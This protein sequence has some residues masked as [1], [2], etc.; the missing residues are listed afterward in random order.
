MSTSSRLIWGS[1]TSWARMCVTVLS[2]TLLVP[3]YLSHWSIK[4]YGVWLAIQS[5]L[6]LLTIPDT[7]HQTF[8]GYEFLRFGKDS[9]EKIGLNLY[10]GAAFGLIISIVQI[11]F[12]VILLNTDSLGSMLGESGLSDN[13]ILHEAGLVLLIQGF[14]WLLC[15]SVSGL[16]SRSLLTFGYFPR[17]SLWILIMGINTSF[18]PVIPVMFGAGLLKTAI[19]C[20]LSTVVLAVL[21][22]LD[23][24]HLLRKEK[25]PFIFPSLKLG[26]KNFTHSLALSGRIALENTRQQG[27]R[28]IVAPLAGITGLAA[29]S[30]MRT[31]SNF[32]LQGLNTI[33]YPLMPELSRFLHQ[34][35]QDRMEAGFGT[36]WI[37]LI[38]VLA[39]S[40]VILQAFAEPL[41][42]IWTRGK[43]PF[44]PS[45]FAVLSLSVL[46]Y[47]LGQPAMAI[48][49]G[50]NLLKI[51]FYLSAVVAVIVIAGIYFLLPVIGIVGAGIPLLAAEVFAAIGY[52]IYAARWLKSNGMQ[53]PRSS[54][55]ISVVSVLTSGI[56]MTIMILIPSLK[57]FTLIGALIVLSW[58]LLEYWKALPEI[59]TSNVKK[60]FFNIPGVKKLFAQ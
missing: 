3:I 24:F 50:N 52:K 26:F 11:I 18:A 17:M 7:G 13:R 47:A 33:T 40:V 10:S 5:L 22:Y 59:A 34:R 19:V 53:W 41:Y 39:P 46:V 38:I 27:V 31:M 16:L 9:R 43:L 60:I 4:T 36:L 57:W 6:Y 14:T 2:Q 21:Q 8:L 56:A 15:T 28:L 30:T 1:V 20:A 44:S 54:Y 45:L 55:L 35:D 37:V 48:I 58:T 23:M 29:F 32:A 51:Q 42:S 49:I 12:I 25:V